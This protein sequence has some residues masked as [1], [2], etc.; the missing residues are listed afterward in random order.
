MNL[1]L[2]N[3]F[4]FLE[5]NRE[6]SNPESDLSAHWTL[7]RNALVHYTWRILGQGDQEP[8]LAY[9]IES[10]G[11]QQEKDVGDHE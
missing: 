5:L 1:K 6:F 2:E 7:V 3:I 8:Q 11:K 9:E 4:T 10:C